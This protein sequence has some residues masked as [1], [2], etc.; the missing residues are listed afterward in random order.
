LV[1]A[2]V[3]VVETV[4]RIL[5]NKA[6][7]VPI[8][9]MLMITQETA[10]YIIKR[11]D[12]IPIA[13][14]EVPQLPP[15]M[16]AIGGTVFPQL[17][18][19]TSQK[20]PLFIVKVP[21]I[22]ARE[23]VEAFS[24]LSEALVSWCDRNEFERLVILDV[25]APEGE[26][27]TV[28]Y[29]AEERLIKDMEKLGFKPTSGRLSMLSSYLL[30]QCIKSRIDGVL[31]EIESEVYGRVADIYREFL[32]RGPKMELY[33]KL[34]TAVKDFDQDAVKRA[35]EAVSKVSGVEIP[36]DKLDEHLKGIKA[37]FRE[38]FLDTMRLLKSQGPI[39]R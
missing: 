18:I 28:R 16:V 15:R 26:A 6:M 8:P 9:D 7:I 10:K 23:E 21:A 34:A 32:L 35:V 22:L 12:M 20:D 5:R 38:F 13:Y 27:P 1:E 3:R 14:I 31:L 33:S 37:S 36:L 30:N 19:Y 2:R 4:F 29:A 39:I 11:L 25:A 24:S 17:S